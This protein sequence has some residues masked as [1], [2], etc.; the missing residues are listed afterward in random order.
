MQMVC[1]YECSA[2]RV[3]INSS[4]SHRCPTFWLAWDALSEDEFSWAA[5]TQV[6][7][8]VMPPVYFCGNKS[9]YKEH[10]DTI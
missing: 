4:L 6:A 7:P 9:R 8:K 2:G 5:Q 3:K 1:L 10:N